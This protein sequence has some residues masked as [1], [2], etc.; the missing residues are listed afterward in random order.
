MRHYSRVLHLFFLLGQ[1]N[2]FQDW[3][4]LFLARFTRLDLQIAVK[5]PLRLGMLGCL[6]DIVDG[7]L[8]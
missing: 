1:E 4:Q 7:L 6:L 5:E 2:R 3:Q 8:A